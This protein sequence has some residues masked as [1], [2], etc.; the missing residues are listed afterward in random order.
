MGFSLRSAAFAA[1]A[2]ST[3]FAAPQSS[4]ED[5]KLPVVDLGYERHQ[6]SYYN[7]TGR[8]FNFTNI[9]YAAPRT[10]NTV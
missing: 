4:Y 5:G 1:L 7:D 6:A 9:R 8:F 3:A 10:P 2:A